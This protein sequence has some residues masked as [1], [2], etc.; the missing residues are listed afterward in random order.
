M[1]GPQVAGILATVLEDHPTL[2]PM[3]AKLLLF[4]NCVVGAISAT[5][6]SLFTGG[7]SYNDTR[8]YSLSGGNNYTLLKYPAKR[9]VPNLQ[10]GENFAKYLS[11]C[12]VKVGQVDLKSVTYGSNLGYMN[13]SN[14]LTI[15]TTCG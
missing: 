9:I 12:Y 6:D 7:G 4:E 8:L 11:A 2:S 5:N 1:A 14:D 15:S 3:Q 10:S 13:T